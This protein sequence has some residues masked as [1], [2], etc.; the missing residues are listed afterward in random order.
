MKKGSF[1][2]L[3]VVALLLGSCNNE[4]TPEKVPGT[5][6]VLSATIDNGVQ[7]RSNVT[8]AGAFTWKT[9]DAIAVYTTSGS[10]RKG[11]LR[12]DSDGQSQGD[13]D[14]VYSGDEKTSTCAVYPY[15]VGH[16]L[17]GQS[18]TVHLANQYDFEEGNTNA[19]MLAL[20]A[21]DGATNLNFRHIGGVARFKMNR[22]P[23]GATRFVFTTPGM[24]ITGDFTIDDIGAADPVIET[25]QNT[26]NNSVTFRFDALQAETNM[27][28]YVPLPA[29][30]YNKMKIEIQSDGG[31][32]LTSSE[33][34]NAN[35]IGR[36]TLL[37][38]PTL[39]CNSVQGG[40]V[41]SAS[42]TANATDML[43]GAENI[44]SIT[45]SELGTTD[46]PITIPATYYNA[47]TGDKALDLV[48][49]TA[50]ANAE[51]TI[52]AGSGT[53]GESKLR[54]NLTIP[55]IAKLTVTAPTTTMT[56]SANDGNPA[57]IA[58]LTALTA[59]NTLIIDKDVTVTTLKIKGGNVKIEGKVVNIQRTE[60]NPSDNTLVEIVGEGTLDNTPTDDKIMVLSTTWDGTS[61]KEP[62]KLNGIYQIVF[63]SELAW[64]QGE[65]GHS[66]TF[67]D[68]PSTF[69]ADAVLLNDID[70]ADYPW[71]GM[72]LGDNRRFDGNGHTVSNVTIDQPSLHQ[73]A[74][75]TSNKEMH[76]AC[77]GLFGATKAEA[78]LSNI[79][80]KNVTIT[81]TENSNI[82]WVGGLVGCSKG[83]TEF[84]D[85]HA[86]NVTISI[87][88]GISYRAGGLIGYIER[89]H[90]TLEP[91]VTLAQCSAKVI[92]IT[93]NYSYGGLVGS[94][95]DAVKFDQCTTSGVTLHLSATANANYGYVS[96]FIGDI[97]NTG[98]HAR[99]MIINNCSAEAID[100]SDLGFDN[101]LKE[102]KTY[103]V[104]SPFVGIVDK[105]EE[106]TI[107]V[108]NKTLESG[109]DFN[110][111]E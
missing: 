80:V 100:T 42:S 15:H 111:Y 103:R 26:A 18:L 37:K 85:C 87:N 22:M 2:G 46:A 79:T 101:I 84:T 110:V 52:D 95:W 97:T 30:T 19:P 77:M 86:E 74:I 88:G 94:T 32:V 93:A 65:A 13:F 83:T 67:N 17:N 9:G 60:D 45:L 69:N 90:Q 47:G 11:T 33:S 23:V 62:A 106:M 25:K 75:E 20:I 21:A 1:L 54:T 28:F 48:V 51:L 38:M 91:S 73:A 16:A 71:V 81:P 96:G 66:S 57:T 98:S 29:G 43:N 61:K 34:T 10:W 68:L 92:D 59:N 72:V 76:R 108:D 7:T 78:K 63:A 12:P 82:K 41:N 14:I 102:G 105:P 55:T 24:E 6:T 107:I 109:I 58:E 56:V 31:N 104:A 4:D 36:A 50:D 5:C 35:T 40:I 8:E 70:L 27:I 49:E 53:A 99:K 64:F 3:A 44:S 39:T 89:Y